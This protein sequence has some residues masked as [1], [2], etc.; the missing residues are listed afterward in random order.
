MIKRYYATKDNTITNAYAENLTTRGSD[1]NMGASDILEVFSIYGQTQDT[2]G[3][4]STEEARVLIQFDVSQLQADITDGSLD[5]TATFYLRL[6]NAPHGKTLPLNF[7]IEVVPLEE[8]WQEG[9]GMDME[10]YTDLTYGNGSSWNEA[11]ASANWTTSGGH[12]PAG[13]PVSKTFDEGTE[14]L[15]IDVT[16]FVSTWLLT[17]ET[18][19]GL[20][21]KLPTTATA[22]TRSYYTKMFFARST[23]NFFKKPTLE[24]RW[25]S[26]VKDQRNS[27]Y[28]TKQNTVYLYNEF[29]GS[30]VDLT[31]P[32]TVSFYESLGGIAL[33]PS[34]V[35]ATEVTQGI[36]KA[37][38]T[39]TTSSGTIYDVWSA[40]G[41]EVHSGSI[42]II[43]PSMAS[44]S[45]ISD[46]VVSVLN[47]QDSHYSNQTS[48]F[49]FYIREK[50]WS[51]NIH[52][53]ATTRPPSKVYDKLV[54]K[55]S[56][57]V[58][59]E[60]VFD[61][62]FENSST[63]LSYDANGNFFDLDIAMLEVNYV[64]EIKLALF[65]VMTK[66]YQELP[67]K[68]RFRVVNNEH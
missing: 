36:Y 16:S 68:H 19:F 14:D 26:Q 23:S 47:N 42:S 40:A 50:N 62:D 4:F 64:Y 15:L 5:S 20:I 51:P 37:D 32:V 9:T 56:R 57:V 43:Q 67:F 10:G 49:Y 29:R 54:Y 2:L 35:T 55:I 41:T 44:E 30:L 27:F 38:V 7:E 63:T 6:F 12:F 52:T 8:A 33:G 58:T 60:V 28:S 34:P 45:S 39:L 61:Y 21:V 24:A 66:S 53:V 3:A 22:E 1:A 25:D 11:G 59:D 46:L 17:P 13:T 65:N 18:N 48:R 31:D